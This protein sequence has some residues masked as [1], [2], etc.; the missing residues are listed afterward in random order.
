MTATLLFIIVAAAVGVFAGAGLVGAR[1]QPT[2]T[3]GNRRSVDDMFAY[4]MYDDPC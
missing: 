4:T 2:V 3:A 1:R